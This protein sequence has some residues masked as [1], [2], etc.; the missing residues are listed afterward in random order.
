MGTFSEFSF[1]EL[2][3]EVAVER[4]ITS[5]LLLPKIVQRPFLLFQPLTLSRF[6]FEY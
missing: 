5:N 4:W 2:F 6:F 3:F 1:T